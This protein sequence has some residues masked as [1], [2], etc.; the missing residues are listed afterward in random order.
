M[1]SLRKEELRERA[2][3]WIDRLAGSG[4][5]ASLTEGYS[6][7]GGGSLPGSQLSTWL[8][9]IEADDVVLV[10]RSL[11]SA[12]TA[13]IGRIADDR[14]LLDPRTVL[15]EQDE[16]LIDSVVRAV[17]STRLDERRENNDA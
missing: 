15:E 7:V 3:A 1:I 2:L 10:E 5:H 9:A 12:E 11:R 6:T 17:A 16:L 8:V 14:L 13:V 4:I